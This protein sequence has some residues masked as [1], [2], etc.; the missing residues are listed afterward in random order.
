MRQRPSRRASPAK[1]AVHEHVRQMLVLERLCSRFHRIAQQLQ[2]R[3]RVADE[4]EAQ[5]FLHA[6]LLLEHDDV[7]PETWTPSYASEN[8]RTDFL[9]AL[10]RTVM[11][12]KMTRAGL[13]ASELREQLA[14]DVHHYQSRPDCKTV[15]YF[16]Y[17]PD[18]R[19]AD[20]RKLEIELSG[21]TGGLAVRV[22]IAPQTAAD[23]QS[24]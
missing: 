12:A 14:V 6:L 2:S 23:F 21:D 15:V 1:G 19:I 13:G 11:V 7:R 16:V 20:A 3:L 22:F 9:L 24:A 5:D 10:E 8:S 4:R 17:D 18:G